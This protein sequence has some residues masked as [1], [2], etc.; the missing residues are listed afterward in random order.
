MIKL[1]HSADWHLDS[2]L[3]GRTPEQ[4]ALLRAQLLAVPGKLAQLCRAEQCD[5][6][7][8]SGDL[9]DGSYT[10][11]SYRAVYRALEEAAVPVFVAP[12]NH[13]YLSPESPWRAEVWPENVHIFT[14]NHMTGVEVP[15][16]DCCVYGAAFHGSDCD[17]LLEGFRADTGRTYAVGVLHGDPTQVTSPYCPVSERQV[18]DS[19][20]HYLALGHIHKEGAFRAGMTLCGWPGCPMGRGFDELDEKG[21]LIVTLD[22]S[23]AARFVALDTV[24]FH[25]LQAAPGE[26]AAAALADILPPVGNDD[27]YRII[28]T[29][30][31]QPLDL[32]ALRAQLS[33]FPNLELRDRTTVPIDPWRTVDEDS[34]EGTFFRMLRDAMEGADGAQRKR[35]LL[36]AEISR[37]L[38][39]GQEVP[40][41]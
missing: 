26:D 34:L 5:L 32:T 38:L 23:A 14:A 17:G 18:A 15:D 12:G 31:S 19:G 29:G 22:G 21:A 11:E 35:I 6:M 39:D 30:P 37:Q 24:R 3:Q 10:P 27:F 40:L 4:T 1:L 41:P 25:D 20:L 2:P 28:L 13:D 16:L 33:R 9:F 8:L 7:L 36:A